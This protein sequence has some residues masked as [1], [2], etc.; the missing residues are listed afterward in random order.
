[1]RSIAALAFA[2]A[3]MCLGAQGASAQEATWRVTSLTGI[4][5]VRS[6]A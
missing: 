1:M 2:L 6:L 4:V 5:R 3:F